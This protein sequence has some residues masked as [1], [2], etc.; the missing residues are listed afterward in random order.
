MLGV[1]GQDCA[2]NKFFDVLSRVQMYEVTSL[3]RETKDYK[4]ILVEMYKNEFYE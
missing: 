4:T 1:G 3:Q 2:G